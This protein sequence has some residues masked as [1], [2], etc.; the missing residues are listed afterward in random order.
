MGASPTC[1][2]SLV[3]LGFPTDRAIP[4]DYHGNTYH[5]CCQ[6]CADLFMTDPQKY[7]QD[8]HDLVVCPTCLAEKPRSQAVAMTQ[9]GQEVHFCR[10]PYCQEAFQK[11][12]EFY[13]QRLAGAIPNAG[14]LDHEACCVRPEL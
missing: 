1:G 3:R 8:S 6:G 14:V 13:T 2:C 5:F 7:L 12:P 11:N 4:H 9:A 10:C